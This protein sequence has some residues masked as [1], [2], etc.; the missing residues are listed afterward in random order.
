M[1]HSA[2][3]VS[4][5]EGALS[6]PS[7]PTDTVLQVMVWHNLTR[8]ER[9]LSPKGILSPSI[10]VISAH[11]ATLLTFG[12]GHVDPVSVG[13]IDASATDPLP[14]VHPSAFLLQFGLVPRPTK[15]PDCY[16]T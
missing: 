3:I 16:A 5:D 9:I 10:P 13:D 8:S 15:G 12:S 1:C 14:D 7:R 6:Q 11:K 4:D 2:T